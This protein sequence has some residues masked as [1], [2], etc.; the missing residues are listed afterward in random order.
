MITPGKTV[1]GI[2]GWRGMVGSV[3]LERM[4]AEGDFEGADVRF[5]STSQVGRLGPEVPGRSAAPLFDAHKID[6]LAQCEVILSSQGG[7]YTKEVYPALRSGG[8][9]GY[10]IDAASALRMSDESCIILDPVNRDVI[11][12]ALESGVRTFVGGNCTVSL[13]LMAL[14]PLFRE[15]LVEWIS[16][17]TYQAAS[18]AGA[19]QMEELLHQSLQC[20]ESLPREFGAL[21]A[22]QRVREAMRHT[23]LPVAALGA[24][25]AFSVL[26][27]ID[28]PM[29]DGKSREEWKGEVELNRILDLKHRVAVDGVCVRV[30]VLRSHSQAFL[31]K[32]KRECALEDVQALLQDWNKWIDVV[33]NEKPATLERL[34]PCAVTGTLTVAVGRL[35]HAQFGRE[36][37]AGFTVGDQLLWGAA[38]PLR[39][40]WKILRQS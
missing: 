22:E 39:R 32:M 15:N 20:T 14:A 13:L 10:W 31:L 4:V 25:L 28:M 3:L 1:L 7:E 18:G 26:P 17:M 37:I 19:R 11:D 40:M 9:K 33:P 12:R 6:E 16:S 2:V 35:R 23:E 8:W 29:D 30:P 38:E 34:T 24:P 27:F 36:Y 5:F 21:E